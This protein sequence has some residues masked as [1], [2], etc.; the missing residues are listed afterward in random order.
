[1][2]RAGSR[3][4]RTSEL[5]PG[6]IKL[7]AKPR[8]QRA[9][10]QSLASPICH[11]RRERVAPPRPSAPG[12]VLA[13]QGG[14]TAANWRALVSVP[15]IPRCAAIASRTLASQRPRWRPGGISHSVSSRAIELHGRCRGGARAC[16][17]SAIS[18][19]IIA[20]VGRR[21][22]P[23]PPPPAKARRCASPPENASNTL[24]E[25]LADR[26][27]SG[28]SS[29]EANRAASAPRRPRGFSARTSRPGCR[30]V[31]VQRMRDAGFGRD[32]LPAEALRGRVAGDQRLRR[33]RDQPRWPPPVCGEPVWPSS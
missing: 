13:D 7:K 28:L 14:E 19:R 2:K 17:M 8:R 10:A 11:P 18:R 24:V 9:R 1:M 4:P 33:L 32:V 29:A 20:C 30:N 3:H 27:I 22:H 6:Q 16:S 23:D 15:S 12:S 31:Q 25:L 26:S 21:R 5:P